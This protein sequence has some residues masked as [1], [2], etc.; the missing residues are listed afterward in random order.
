VAGDESMCIVAAQQFIMDPRALTGWEKRLGVAVYA[1]IAAMFIST[2]PQA[3]DTF[4]TGIGMLTMAVLVLTVGS[5]RLERTSDLA[6]EWLRKSAV[7]AT[8][9]LV[10]VGLPLITI[11]LL[12]NF[13]T[14][15][16]VN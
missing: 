10:W 11:Y 4:G 13:V 15:A 14:R 7:I 1:F 3:R 9:A 16:W 6:L 5:A 8:A 12:V 2:G